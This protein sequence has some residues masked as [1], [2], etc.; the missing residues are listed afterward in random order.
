MFCIDCC[1][2]WM[3]FADCLDGLLLFGS[4]G[5]GLI[6]LRDTVRLR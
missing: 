4:L 2:P 1:Y 3:L 5:C 6:G